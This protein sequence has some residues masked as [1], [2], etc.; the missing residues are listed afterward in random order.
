VL[1]IEKAEGANP[2]L[3]ERVTDKLTRSGLLAGSVAARAIRLD[4][5]QRLGAVWERGHIV[6]GELWG[7]YCRYPYL[8]RLRDRSVLVEGVESTL[9]SMT[10]ER[11]G[12]ALADSYDEAA[13]TYRGLVLP[14]GDAHFGQITDSTLLV[15]PSVANDQVQQK[16]VPPGPGP[17]GPGPVPPVVGPTPP[18]PPPGPTAPTRYFGVFR[19]DPERYARDLTRVSQEVLHQLAAVEGSRIEVSVEIQAVS[20]DGFPDDK[21]RVVLENARTLGFEQSSFEDE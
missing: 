19:L 18:L 6:I 14:S 16:V 10:W 1:A 11:E 15:V 13:G 3:A 21:I 9:S 2:R 17:V 12:F 4:L 5:D 7:Y 20:A 8:T